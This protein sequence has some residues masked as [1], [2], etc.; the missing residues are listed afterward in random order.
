MG[1]GSAG[2]DSAAN[3]AV[4]ARAVDQ[5]INGGDLAVDERYD[6][7]IA[8]D[9][10]VWVAPFRASFPDVHRAPSGWSPRATPSSGPSA[11]PAP[12]SGWLG[13]EPTGRRFTEGDEV[14]WFTRGGG[15]ITAWREMED[16]TSRLRQLRLPEP[17]T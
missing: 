10:K 14:H 11:A 7:G 4:V 9:A 13:K 3:K 17:A 16:N 1:E 15:R 2:V 12:T 6:P 8:S 5:V